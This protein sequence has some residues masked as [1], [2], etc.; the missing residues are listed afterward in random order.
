MDMETKKWLMI[1]GVAI[2]AAASGAIEITPVGTDLRFAV[3]SIVL[4]FALLVI[5]SLP[6]I[7]T[8]LV[9][10]VLIFTLRV[11]LDYNLRVPEADLAPIAWSQFPGAFYYFL[12]GLFMHLF[13]VR[14]YSGNLAVVLVLI[15]T[16]DVTANL[17]ELFIRDGLAAVHLRAVGYLFLVSTIR[18]IWIVSVVALIWIRQLQAKQQEELL[19]LDKT[20]MLLSGLHTE[21][22][23]LKKTFKEL[24]EIMSGSYKIFAGLTGDDRGGEIAAEKMANQ[25]S[26]DSLETGEYPSVERVAGIALHLSRKAH[27]IKKDFQRTLAGLEKFVQSEYARSSMT[28]S[29]LIRMIIRSH[30]NYV[31]SKGLNISFL[32][33]IKVN[34]RTNQVYTLTSIISNLVTNAEEAIDGNG[35][36][37]IRASRKDDYLCL[38]VADNGPGIPERK[39]PRIFDIGYTTK[40]AADGSPYTG[41]GLNHVSELAEKLGGWIEV[42]PFSDL[43][44][45]GKGATFR[46]MLLVQS[47]IGAGE[48]DHETLHFLPG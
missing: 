41:I 11:I 46:V 7:T 19:H 17:V 44:G 35:T 6:L 45:G 5:R 22:F 29:D 15:V 24:E 12:I 37:E 23:F 27:E 13:K 30:C 40:F 33:N 39:L 48:E 34:L 21:A 36:V 4:I 25:S 42:D 10:A 16:A 20:V 31:Q 1:A 28:L 8:G 9:T 43:P 18:C 3:A 47:I 14:Q 26:V 38:E 32:E 2:L